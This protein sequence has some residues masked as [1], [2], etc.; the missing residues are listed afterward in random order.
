MKIQAFIRVA[1]LAVLSLVFAGCAHFQPVDYAAFREHRP[2]SILV[3]PPLNHST[4]VEGTYGYLSTA[5]RPLAEMG[6]YVFPVAEID[7]FLK[8]NGMPTAGEMHQVPLN[9]VAEIIG[10]DAVLYIT[11]DKY[12]SKYQIINSATVVEASAKLVDTKT[13]LTLWQGNARAEEDSSS[14]SN[15]IIAALVAAAVTQV[16]NSSV[17]EAHNVSRSANTMLFTPKNRGLLLGPYHP[18]FE[19]DK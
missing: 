7:E 16:V 18:D 15:N 1:L 4:A 19:K 5:T 3:L 11:L 6:Y 12:G 13:G 8:A 14:G 2:H 10:A 17:D 9:K